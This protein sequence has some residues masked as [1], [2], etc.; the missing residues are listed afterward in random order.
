M[1]RSF[2]NAVH[3]ARLLAERGDLEG[4]WQA[5]WNH[6]SLRWPTDKAQVA[7]V[8][9]LTDPKLKTLLHQERCDQILALPRGLEA[10]KIAPA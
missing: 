3:I 9:L 6:M 1:L 4:G 10:A 7:P 5:L 2:N 8:I